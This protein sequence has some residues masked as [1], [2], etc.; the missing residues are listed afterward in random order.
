MVTHSEV[1]ETNGLEL[2]T[3]DDAGT[4]MKRFALVG[5]SCLLPQTMYS[6]GSDNGHRRFP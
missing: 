1:V 2:Q 6:P 4:A 5:R 3:E